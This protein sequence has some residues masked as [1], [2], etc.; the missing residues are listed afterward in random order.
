[1]SSNRAK[2][3]HECAE[4]LRILSSLPMSA[5]A[6]A[7]RNCSYGKWRGRRCSSSCQMILRWAE[8][9]GP[10]SEEILGGEHA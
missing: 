4:E 6:W 5:L 10:A 2:T 3:Y 8:T 1:M 7:T 9:Q